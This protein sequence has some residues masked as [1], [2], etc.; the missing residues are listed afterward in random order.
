M[1][2]GT[3]VFIIAVVIFK[4]RVNRFKYNGKELQTGEFNDGS[5]LTWDDY[6]ARM[7]DPQ[8][9]RWMVVDPLAQKFPWQSPYLFCDD[10]PI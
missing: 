1:Y 3:W 6:G 10:N 5:G 2:F 8:I 4:V 7:Y 9:G